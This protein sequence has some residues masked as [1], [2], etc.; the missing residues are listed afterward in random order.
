MTVKDMVGTLARTGVST[1]VTVV[2]HPIG[3]ASAVVGFAK[4][5]AE[6]GSHLVRSTISGRIP[7]QREEAEVADLDAAGS[8]PAPVPTSTPPVEEPI[9]R[10]DAGPKEPQVVPKP[11]PSIEDLPEPDVIWA[12]DD[13]GEPVHTEPKAASRDSEHGG[14]A[15]DRE[16]ADGYA[17]EIPL[18]DI[19]AD[20]EVDT[21]WTSESDRRTE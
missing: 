2:R 20:P 19:G 18:E 16:E 12:E 6:A 8:A 3:S 7:L 9:A 21:V 5:A 17:E 13:L 4:G 10:P 15:G 11:V 1:A 14:L